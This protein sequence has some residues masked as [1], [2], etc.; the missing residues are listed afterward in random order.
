MIIFIKSKTIKGLNISPL[1]L[2]NRQECYDVYKKVFSGYPWFEDLAC[3]TKECNAQFS[4]NSRVLENKRDNVFF[5]PEE[6]LERCP[7]C[8]ENLFLIEYYPDVVNQRTLI[9]ESLDLD[10][11]VGYLLRKDKEVIGFT[12]G[13]K[14]PEKRTESVNFPEVRLKL[15]NVS[16]DPENTFYCAET[17]IVDSYQNKGLGSI[18]VAQRI[19]GAIKNDFETITNRTI[20]S[21]MRKIMNKIFS[22]TP[23]RELFKD[24]EKTTPWF[25][26][27]AKDVDLKYIKNILRGEK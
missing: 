25:A 20:N 2:K 26:W 15:E 23:G 14:I 4:K 7:L 13:Y 9:D 21:Y 12:W 16:I 18:V 5:L 22:N 8:K 1:D 17:G 24:P 10:K 6:K 19:Y 27:N 3:S 11:F